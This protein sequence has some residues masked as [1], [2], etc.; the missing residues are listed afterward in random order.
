VVLPASDSP[1]DAIARA[2]AGG[3]RLVSVNPIRD[4]LEDFFVAQV[5]GSERRAFG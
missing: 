3:A 2:R 1:D 5:R 4:T